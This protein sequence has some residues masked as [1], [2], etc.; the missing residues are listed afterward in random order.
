[1]SYHLKGSIIAKGLP[2]LLAGLLILGG[3][4]GVWAAPARGPAIFVPQPTFN[5]GKVIEGKILIHTFVIKNRGKSDLVIQS[6]KP[7]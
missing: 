2:A 6:V 1:M 7:G 4:L 5:A 3:A